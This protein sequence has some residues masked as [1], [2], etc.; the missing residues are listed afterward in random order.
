MS[1]NE[2]EYLEDKKLHILSEWRRWRKDPSLSDDLVCVIT[3]T[4]MS[5]HNRVELLARL[6]V[7]GV[8][9][10][11]DLERFEYPAGKATPQMAND[12]AIWVIYVLANSLPE[13]SKNSPRETCGGMARMID[14]GVSD[15]IVT[16]ELLIELIFKG[17]DVPPLIPN[18]GKGAPAA[19]ELYCINPFISEHFAITANVWQEILKMFRI[20]ET[21]IGPSRFSHTIAFT[22]SGLVLVLVLGNEIGPTEIRSHSFPMEFIQGYFGDNYVQTFAKCKEEGILVEESLVH[23]AWREVALS[24]GTRFIITALV[25]AGPNTIA[26]AA[27]GG[28]A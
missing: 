10:E 7:E 4:S 5:F 20:E 22:P 26:F 14:I 23:Q 27:P 18:L 3:E 11:N 2:L 19:F 21:Q 17:W 24:L 1:K 13:G 8:M 15:D 25:D 9:A 28:D 12:K 16:I 6:H